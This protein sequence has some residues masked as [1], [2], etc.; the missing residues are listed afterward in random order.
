MKQLYL[1]S[2]RS[3]KLARV[4]PDVPSACFWLSAELAAAVNILHTFPNSVMTPA[5]TKDEVSIS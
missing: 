5:S 1:P 3:E 2:L 4:T